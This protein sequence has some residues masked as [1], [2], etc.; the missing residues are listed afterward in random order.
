MVSGCKARQATLSVGHVG[1]LRIALQIRPV[2]LLRVDRK[3]TPP[4]YGFT[5]HGDESAHAP[6]QRT[7]RKGRYEFLIAAER[8]ALQG[9]YISFL[10]AAEFPDRLTLQFFARPNLRRRRRIRGP[11]HNQERPRDLRS[12]PRH[13]N[14]IGLFVDSQTYAGEQAVQPEPPG[15]DHLA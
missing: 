7:V 11:R 12:I 9:R 3:R 1:A 10:I 14:T 8:I 2:G 4:S 15:A 6:P 5:P 13:R